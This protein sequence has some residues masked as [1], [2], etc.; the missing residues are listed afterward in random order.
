MEIESET[1]NLPVATLFGSESDRTLNSAREAVHSWAIDEISI[2]ASPAG[3]TWVSPASGLRYAQEYR[4]GL[5]SEDRTAD[6][7]VRMVRED[8][9]IFIDLTRWDLGTTIKYEGLATVT[10]TLDGSP[11]EG[12]AIVEVQPYGHQ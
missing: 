5:D 10:G 4:I 1:G 7:T 3:G 9:E 12:T 8:Q 2:E 11:I 6:L